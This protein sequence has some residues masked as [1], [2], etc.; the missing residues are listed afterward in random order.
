MLV[1]HSLLCVFLS[2]ILL[3]SYW[4]IAVWKFQVY[5]IIFQFLYRLHHVHHEQSSF[6]P[7]HMCSFTLFTLPLNLLLLWQPLIY[8]PY[9]C[10]KNIFDGRKSID[11]L[12]LKIRERASMFRIYGKSLR[13]VWLSLPFNCKYRSPL[14][15]ELICLQLIV[16]K[17]NSNTW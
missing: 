7:S 14:K 15:L 2:I 8:S 17:G 10:Q 11:T 16:A 13:L 9:L 4:L 3:E 1:F 6:H 12:P 5:I